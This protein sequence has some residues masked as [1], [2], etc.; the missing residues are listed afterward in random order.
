MIQ[1]SSAVAACWPASNVSAGT[2]FPV[3]CPVHGVEVEHGEVQG[4]GQL[5]RHRG[6]ARSRSSDD[7][8]PLWSIT[9]IH[10]SSSLGETCVAVPGR[11]DNLGVTAVVQNRM[12]GC[13][14]AKADDAPR[15]TSGEENS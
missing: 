11:P 3:R 2:G 4:L 5:E 7:G 1:R 10:Q 8:H 12:I 9:A 14:E 6:L 13:L 15:I